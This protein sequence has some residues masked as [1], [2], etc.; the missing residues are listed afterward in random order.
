MCV[1]GSVCLCDSIA[2][3][4]CAW[5]EGKQTPLCDQRVQTTHPDT[6]ILPSSTH[7][8]RYTSNTHHRH[9][10]TRYRNTHTLTSHTHTHTHT[11]TTQRY[12]NTLTSHP[13]ATHRPTKHRNVH[14][15]FRSNRAE[16]GAK[17][18]HPIR[19][20]NETLQSHQLPGKTQKQLRSQSS[21][22]TCCQLKCFT[23]SAPL[24]TL[25]HTVIHI[26]TFI[27][28]SIPMKAEGG[29]DHHDHH[30]SFGNTVTPAH[31]CPM[32]T[33]HHEPHHFLI[34]HAKDRFYITYIVF[35]CVHIFSIM[36][37]DRA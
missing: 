29:N 6:H 36:C 21:F 24:F 8:Y 33:S 32:A 19:C 4:C 1:C 25:I 11:P 31:T 23:I 9:A 30:L 17:R 10:H 34:G 16:G 26:H 15:T 7:R 22:L 14:T 13:H 3:V 37:A 27:L 35:L 20:Q 5:L 28:R 18:G 2:C 12:A